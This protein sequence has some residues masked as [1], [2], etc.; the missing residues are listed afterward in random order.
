MFLPPQ[1][2]DGA[3]LSAKTI[4]TCAIILQC[5][6]NPNG[7]MRVWENIIRSVFIIA[8]GSDLYEATVAVNSSERL[9]EPVG[10]GTAGGVATWLM[11]V[12]PPPALALTEVSLAAGGT[13]RL[14]TPVAEEVAVIDTEEADEDVI[15]GDVKVTAGGMAE[16]TVM[17]LGA[18]ER[19]AEA[20]G[21]PQEAETKTVETTVTV[22][23][24]SVPITTVGV[25]MAALLEEVDMAAELVRAVVVAGG[26]VGKVLGAWRRLRRMTDGVVEA[27][28][29]EV[30][31]MVVGAG[32]FT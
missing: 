21:R 3:Q 1:L 28:D 22:T 4:I 25:T 29:C 31:Y 11:K 20:E 8:H 30:R 24:P 27:D 15:A 13:E 2:C 32:A 17:A 9:N 16:E 26:G 7:Y 23:I 12:S 10:E 14:M 6:D 19:V 18:E 5:N